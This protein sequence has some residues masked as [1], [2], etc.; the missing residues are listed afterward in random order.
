MGK[1]I[2]WCQVPLTSEFVT[3][4]HTGLE[5]KNIHIILAIRDT[6][7]EVYSPVAYMFSPLFCSLIDHKKIP[8]NFLQREKESKGSIKYK[9]NKVSFDVI[10]KKTTIQLNVLGK[11]TELQYSLKS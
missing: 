3:R 5:K 2:F 7:T 9:T 6:W 1:F 10:S 8:I 4:N 11:N